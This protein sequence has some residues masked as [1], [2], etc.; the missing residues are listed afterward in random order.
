MLVLT[1]GDI[2]F[3]DGVMRDGV[4]MI[5]NG[6]IAGTKHTSEY[7]LQDS[8]TVI[9]CSDTFI[10]PGFIDIHNQGGMGFSVMD[11]MAE[12]VNGMC[13]AHA[14]HGTTGLLLTP[15]ID[16]STFRDLLPVLAGTV[17]ADTGGAGILGIHAEGPFTNPVRQGFMPGSGILSPTAKLLDEILEAG[18]GKI[19]E[20]TIAP[21]LD[22]ALDLISRLAKEGVVASLGHSDATLEDVLRAIDH[23]AS[24]VTHM[25]NAMS[26][27]H[28]REPG[29]AGAALYSTD[30]S[31]E[32]IAD[33]Y[34]IH[35]WILG[36]VLQN[37]GAM[38]TCLITD[39]MSVMGM[40]EGKHSTLGQDVI[41]EDDRLSLAGSPD[42]LAGS[43]LTMDRAVGNMMNMLGISIVDAVFMASTAPAAVIGMENTIGRG[44]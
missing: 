40:D 43:V 30:L 39:S 5:E 38:L 8:H 6:K 29:L 21:E 11:G 9:D 4:V 34:H 24:H 10:C 13:R 3:P 19:V 20:M 23:G 1:G 27:L 2:V 35:P 14:A 15:V 44:A 26:P 42:T 7:D 37:K 33:G 31:V 25:F 22:G 36:L 28:H 18:G 41:L 17:G 32:V 16:D 12:S